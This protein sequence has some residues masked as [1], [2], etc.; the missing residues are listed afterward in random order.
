MC[1]KL[2][3]V[4]KMTENDI[5]MNFHYSLSNIIFPSSPGGISHLS[6]LSGP[7]KTLTNLIEFL[8]KCVFFFSFFYFIKKCIHV[9]LS[10]GLQSDKINGL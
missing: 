1:F 6:L 3:L 2:F 9:L 10:Y 4:K 7:S 5:I 8:H